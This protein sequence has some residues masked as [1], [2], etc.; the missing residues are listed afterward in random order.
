MRKVP[1]GL[2]PVMEVDGGKPITESAVIQQLLEQLFPETP[3]L[4]PAGSAERQRAEGLMRLERRLF[5]D[6]LQWLC[7][8]W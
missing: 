8:S 4:P 3:L 2:L 7:S 1:S 6:W 5:S